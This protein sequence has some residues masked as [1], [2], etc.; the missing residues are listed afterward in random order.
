MRSITLIV[1]LGWLLGVATS[2][3]AAVTLGQVDTFEDGTTMG[4]N[5]GALSPNPPTNV[6]SG[7]PQG[8]GDH[9][10]QNV[11]SGADTAGGK[12][13]LLNDSG[14]WGGNYG[15]AG[16]TGIRVDFVNLGP[17]TLTMRL[18]F[19]GSLT[20]Y[21][22]TDGFR[23]PPDHAWHRVTFDLTHLT[24]LTGTATRTQVLGK[25]TILRIVAASAPSYQGDTV[26]TT[27]GVDNIA[28]ISLNTPVLPTTWGHLKR[29][30][31]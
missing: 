19:F 14:T 22:S 21:G 25:V 16:V 2:G 24:L 18:A 30:Y 29:R 12:W 4:W 20:W 1:T 7:G 11:S 17:D 23:I 5:E 26:A 28:A 3:R 9:Y 13:N 15:T 6:P 27:A 8:A 31:P 10:L